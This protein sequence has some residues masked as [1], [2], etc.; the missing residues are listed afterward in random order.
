MAHVFT[1]LGELT[2][3]VSARKYLQM[4][5]CGTMLLLSEM[6]PSPGER[7]GASNRAAQREA[8]EGVQMISICIH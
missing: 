6:I 1:F 7:P 4:F 3:G 5:A 2:P 8:F